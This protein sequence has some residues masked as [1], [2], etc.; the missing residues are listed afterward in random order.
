LKTAE[1][2]KGVF[3]NLKIHDRTFKSVAFSFPEGNAR[4]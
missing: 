1:S 2:F 3:R 4:D